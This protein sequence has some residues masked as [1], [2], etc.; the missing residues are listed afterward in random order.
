MG[1]EGLGGEESRSHVCVEVKVLADLQET[2]FRAD[3]AHS[4]LWSTDGA[5]Q[6]GICC[7]ACFDRLLWKGLACGIDGC[8]SE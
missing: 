2:L 1:E 4:P 5:Q 6:D 3:L 8:A 7:L